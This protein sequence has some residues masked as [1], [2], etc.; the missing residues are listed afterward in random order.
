LQQ[1][2]KKYEHFSYDSGTCFRVD[3]NYQTLWFA[4]HMHR[5]IEC[6]YVREG[7]QVAVIDGEF[8]ILHAG[9]LCVCLPQVMHG[10][11]S[12]SA[13]QSCYDMAIFYPE[14][15]AAFSASVAGKKFFP[16]VL[17]DS[18]LDDDMRYCISR[19]F[20]ENTSMS[21]I[22]LS[23]WFTV[24]LEGFAQKVDKT[25]LLMDSSIGITQE[26]LIYIN[27]HI[28]EH[29][30]L[31]VLAKSINISEGHLSRLFNRQMK[32]SIPEYISALRVSH[33]RVLLR[34]RRLTMSQ[35]SARSGFESQRSFNR[36]FKEVCGYTPAEY[37]KR[38]LLEEPAGDK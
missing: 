17:H 21:N 2:I 22:S 35:V 25:E 30:S 29:L 4:P 36:A 27:E 38:L 8:M 18:Q 24:L 11:P 28:Q 16:C 3:K 31:S 32:Q 15:V 10:Y 20:D 37:R 26:V 14:Q 7:E 23:G 34:D 13:S 12:I 19:I 1:E 9:D 5:Q 33:A 6:I